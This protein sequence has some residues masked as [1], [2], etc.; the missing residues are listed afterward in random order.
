MET[1]S[2]YG[3]FI[4]VHH[5]R[6]KHHRPERNILDRCPSLRPV[7]G[8]LWA[9]GRRCFQGCLAVHS[10]RVVP[11]VR[12]RRVVHRL[13]GCHRVQ[14]VLAVQVVPEVRALRGWQGSIVQ[15]VRH[16]QGVHRVL[17]VQADR[18]GLA[19]QGLL[20]HRLCRGFRVDQQCLGLLV[21]PEVRGV[22]VDLEGRVCRPVEPAARK[23][24]VDDQ[25]T[26]VG[27]VFQV[28]QVCR[29]C[30]ESRVV[31]EVREYSNCRK[32][33]RTAF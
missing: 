1:K 33:L 6:R 28:R 13:Q 5:F 20:G 25:G 31:L 30:L 18:V 22:L 23:W 10:L 24:G 14:V 4:V 11:S 8:V 29:F 19:G 3:P 7:R 2:I 26:Q 16:R 32:R 27:Q 17:A 9:L 12:V 21:L 15:A